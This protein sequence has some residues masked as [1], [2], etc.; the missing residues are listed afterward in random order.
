MTAGET[1]KSLA[2]D[3]VDLVLWRHRG[4]TDGLTEQTLELNPGLA[5]RGPVLPAGL[6]IILPAAAALAAARET[7]KLWD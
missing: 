3:T 1:V 6:A 5:G 2:G 7:F 4:A